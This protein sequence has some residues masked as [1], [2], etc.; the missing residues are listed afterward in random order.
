MG[1]AAGHLQ[2]RLTKRKKT[3]IRKGRKK[4]ENLE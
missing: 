4:E 3:S 1:I 2:S